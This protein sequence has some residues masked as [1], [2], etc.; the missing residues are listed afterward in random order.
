VR[1]H[2]EP[3]KVEPTMPFSYTAP[4]YSKE[5]Q[6]RDYADLSPE[7]K[8]DIINDA[9]GLNSEETAALNE[10]EITQQELDAFDEALENLPS[11]DN[12]EA[13]IAAKTVICPELVE[14]ETNPSLFLRCENGS[15][16]RAAKR[17][18]AY[19]DFR[20]ELLGNERAFLPISLAE[21][22]AYHEDEEMIRMMRE[23]P[24]YRYILPD[25]IHGRSVLFIEA[26]QQNEATMQ[27]S[28][29]ERLR[30]SFY[31]WH[32]I[33]RKR[34]SISKGVIWI[35]Y[36]EDRGQVNLNV[37]DRIRMKQ[38]VKFARDC[39]P[40]T[41]RATHLVLTKKSISVDLVLP[42]A[43]RFW[44]QDFRLRFFQHTLSKEVTNDSSTVPTINALEPY[45]FV[46]EGL[47]ECLGGTYQFNTSWAEEQMILASDDDDED[48]ERAI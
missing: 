16:H 48:Y 15:P 27:F 34:S 6:A 37:F 35:Y 24:T 19:W 29:Q 44:R 3:V 30:Y 40:F 10:R 47:P 11:E 39:A 43:K 7:Q 2:V 20:V 32:R 4:T 13:A 22:G 12:A 46:Q 17:F 23:S 8:E 36:F 21:G 33:M 42:I 25:D 31:V 5:D 1:T 26:D 28:R 45:G 9:Y 38:V 14:L 41:F 18:A